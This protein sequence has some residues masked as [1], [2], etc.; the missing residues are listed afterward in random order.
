M[1]HLGFPRAFVRE[2]L[3]ARKHLEAELA[4]L[5]RS[6]GWPDDT[7]GLPSVGWV[8]LQTKLAKLYDYLY[9]ATS[10]GVHFSPSEAARSAWSESLDPDAT[11]T[12]MAEPYRRYRTAFS[13]HWLC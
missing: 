12:L 1:R 11:M 4:T 5:G 9:S 7:R 13:L 6:L 3:P 8:A 2:Q 10:R